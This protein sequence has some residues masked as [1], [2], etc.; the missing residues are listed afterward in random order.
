MNGANPP[1]VAGAIQKPHHLLSVVVHVH[2]YI[3]DPDGSE[4]FQPV[5]QQRTPPDRHEGLRPL[6]SQ[7]AK[8]ATAPGRQQEGPYSVL[9]QVRHS[10]SRLNQVVDNGE[11]PDMVGH[12]DDVVGV[13][14]YPEIQVP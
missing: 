4:G 9:C 5:L 13:A 10:P 8:T 12:L 14:R 6:I 11:Q 3:S 2:Q 1:P 7:G